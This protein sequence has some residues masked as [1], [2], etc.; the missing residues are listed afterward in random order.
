MEENKQREE[1]KQNPLQTAEMSLEQNDNM[2]DGLL[3]NLPNQEQVGLS[4]EGGSLYMAIQTCDSGYDYTFFTQDFEEWD[5]GQL[6]NPEFSMA[7]AIYELLSDEG[8]EQARLTAVDY[9]FLMEQ[10]EVAEQNRMVAREALYHVQ[11]ILEE[12]GLSDSVTLAGAKVYVSEDFNP[13][14]SDYDVLVEYSGDMREDDFFNLLHEQEVTINGRPVDFNPITPDKSGTIE[15]YLAALAFQKE[16]EKHQERPLLRVVP[17]GRF[18]RYIEPSE[19]TQDQYIVK[20]GILLTPCASNPEF[21][22]STNRSV[23][24]SYIDPHIYEVAERNRRG[25]P[26]AFREVT[27]APVE[28]PFE[29]AGKEIGI[30]KS[31]AIPCGL[32]YKHEMEGFVLEDKTVLL[33]KER[34]A[35]GN[36]YGGVSL[37]GMMFKTPKMYGAVKDEHGAVTVFRQMREKDFRQ[38]QPQIS[39]KKPSIREQLAK[40]PET[41]P[42][43]KPPVKRADLER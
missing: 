26:T 23:S 5:G 32:V 34:D 33:Q 38:R 24:G 1:R 7:Q 16:Q 18:E 12:A 11:D 2:I 43:P 21:Y 41:K 36:Y 6:D 3:N 29:P 35:Y 17:V 42:V 9:D 39:E 8:W 4:L 14:Y 15:Q 27:D 20:G 25:K 13:D 37:D 31:G 30:A 28:N 19:I 22:E 40:K 10:A